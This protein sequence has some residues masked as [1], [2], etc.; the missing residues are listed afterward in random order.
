MQ[1]KDTKRSATTALL[2]IALALTVTGIAV[3]LATYVDTKAAEA[4]IASPEGGG[5]NA[6]WQTSAMSLQ[7][8]EGWRVYDRGGMDIEGTHDKET[9]RSACPAG[10]ALRRRGGATR[11]YCSSPPYIMPMRSLW[12]EAARRVLDANFR[13]G[14]GD[15]PVVRL[16]FK[17]SANA[18]LGLLPP[19]CPSNAIKGARRLGYRL[20]VP[21]IARRDDDTEGV[22]EAAGGGGMRRVIPVASVKGVRDRVCHEW[23]CACGEVAGRYG[24]AKIFYPP[25][26]RRGEI[27]CNCRS[28]PYW[29]GREG[30]VSSE[31]SG[32]V[33]SLY[34]MRCGGRG[35][36]GVGR[37]ACYKTGRKTEKKWRKNLVRRDKMTIFAV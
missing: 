14:I 32:Y 13:H 24:H 21:H 36:G 12:P 18:L 4:F 29:R 8:D 27:M 6:P 15:C 23:R 33:A 10:R 26:R 22:K 1:Q 34:D 35:D 20:T 30:T 16:P 11:A 37:A 9:V 5:D 7:G 28:G 31:S 2:V 3:T 19:G 25:K 17:R